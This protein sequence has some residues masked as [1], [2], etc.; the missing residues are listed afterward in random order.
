MIHP[1]FEK[2]ALLITIRPMS[3]PT[4]KPREKMRMYGVWF[5][6]AFQCA[7]PLRSQATAHAEIVAK[8]AQEIVDRQTTK[9]PF[10][11]NWKCPCNDVLVNPSC[12]FIRTEKCA[13]IEDAYAPV[14][15]TPVCISLE[16]YIIKRQV[17]KFPG[18]VEMMF[19][20]E[21]AKLYVK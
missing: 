17:V 15:A 10:C 9:E 18:D 12:S 5:D 20:E 14:S 19:C 4:Y 16:T 8:N 7:F 1:M 3:V 11:E 6:E 21:C 2:S 13:N